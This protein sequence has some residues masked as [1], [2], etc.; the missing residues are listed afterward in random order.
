M[1][2]D[3][4]SKLK[5][6]E[7]ICLIDVGYPKGHFV[8]TFLQQYGIQR[9][10]V[11]IIGIDP[12]DHLNLSNRNG[13]FNVDEFYQ[14]AIST[15]PGKAKFNLYDEPGCNSLHKL[16]VDKRVDRLG[17]EDGW[18]CRYEIKKVDEIEVNVV[19]LKS[20]IESAN[21]EIIH[22]LKIDTQ[23]NDI[24]VIKSCEEKIQNVMFVQMESCVAK[25]KNQIMYENQSLIDYDISHMNSLGFE[26]L[27][28]TDHSGSAPPEAD[29][30]F[31]NKRF[32]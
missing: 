23:G 31:Y 22:Y 25:N 18:Y 29:I 9:N 5:S 13:N 16:N 27:K 12:I 30:I 2:I 14:V 26:V 7:N 32:L 28:T 4:Y 6:Y 24:N 3:I 17:A 11:H 20:I 1:T 15:T 10:K 21:R 8:E 19:T